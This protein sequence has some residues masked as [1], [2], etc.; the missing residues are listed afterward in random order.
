MAQKT[1][2]LLDIHHALGIDSEVPRHILLSRSVARTFRLPLGP[3]TQSEFMD[4]SSTSLHTNGSFCQCFLIAAIPRIY[5]FEPCSMAIL[6]DALPFAQITT[7]GADSFLNQ[8]I[9]VGYVLKRF[10]VSFPP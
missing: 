7:D 10:L 9:W 1:Y 6:Q 5:A 4:L 3:L 8:R 2:K